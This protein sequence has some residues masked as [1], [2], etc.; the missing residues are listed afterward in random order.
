M[1][2]AAGAAASLPAADP[3]EEPVDE[4]FKHLGA[5]LTGRS[6]AETARLRLRLFDP[7]LG[8]PLLVLRDAA[9]EHNL[10]EMARYC[11]G[12]GVSLAPHGKTTMSPQLAAR[13]IALG[14]WGV[15]AANVAQARV[16]H[17]FGMPR[18]LIANEV[19]D[20]AGI[21]WL[22]GH[23]GKDACRLLCYVDSVEGA[24]L[25]ETG[26]GGTG[27]RLDVLLEVGSTGGRTGC[28]DESQALEVARQVAGSPALR[29]AGTSGFEGLLAPDRE[30]ASLAT[31]R[32]FLH[33]LRRV[34]E[35]VAAAGH[36]GGLDEVLVSAGGSV[37][38]P[39][40]AG[41]LGRDWELGRPVRLVLRS[42]CYATHDSGIYERSSP[43]GTGAIPGSEPLRPALELW[44][45]VLSRP[46]AGLALLNFGKRDAPFSNGMPA[47]FAVRARSGG[48]AAAGGAEVVALDDQHAYLRLPAGSRLAVGDWV[49]MGISHPCLACDRWSVLPVLDAEDR[50]VDWYR[51]YF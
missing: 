29:L 14:S 23:A 12:H 42:G 16:F 10:R 48:T 27:A 41:E 36:F 35:V 3:R 24:E 22:A 32:A 46:E 19:V 43:F 50:A 8:S 18:V 21:T 49:G 40:V 33:H 37:F 51:L 15:T 34:T 1:G 25:L 4:R 28:R 45:Q 47:P 17:R 39:E 11:D 9:L 2:T 7:E 5:S 30:P 38:F 13:Q 44:A 26:L 20:R 6:L 31:V